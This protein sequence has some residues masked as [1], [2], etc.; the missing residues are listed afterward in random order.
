MLRALSLL[1]LI[2]FAAP[3]AAQSN[4]QNHQSQNLQS[5]NFR[6]QELAEAAQAYREDLL[7]AVPVAKRQPAL[8]P[9]LR[10]DADA[11]YRAKRY[12]QA[13]DDLTRAINFG[14]DDGL[15]WL[16]LAQAFAGAQDEK[17]MVSAYNAYTRSTDPVERG[18]ALFLIGREYDRHDKMK[19]A[20]AAFEAGLGFTQAAAIS[21][22]VEQLRR[23]V[24]FRVTKV[25]ITSDADSPRACLRFNEKISPR[26]DLSFGGFIRATPE[27]AGVVTA[28]GDTLCLDGL[29]HGETYQVEIM[30]GFPADTGDKT[31]AD[32]SAHMVVADRQPSM[33]FSGAG[34]V[35]PREGSAGLPLTTINLDKV[36]VRLVRINERNLVPTIDA[37]K[38]TMSFDPDNVDEIINQDG[39]LV[40][41]GEMAVSGERNRPVVTAIPLSQILHDKGP[42]VYLAVV[43][44][45]DV[46]AGDNPPLVTNWVLVS[47]LGLTTYTGTDGMAV[48]VRSLADAKPLSGVTLRLYARNNGELTNLIT[49]ADGLARIPPGL[50]HGTGGDEPFVIM[51]STQN[52]DF[53]FLEVSRGAFDLSDRGVSGRPQPGPVDAYLYTDRGIYRPGEPV[54]LMTLIRDDKADSLATLPITLRLVRPDG[55]EVDHRQVTGDKL[56]GHEETYQLARDASIGTWRI[57]ARADPKGPAIGSVDI[58]VEDFVPPQLKVEMSASDA[59]VRPGEDYP[60]N[61]AAR[62]YYGAP[63]AELAV[64]AHATVAIDDNPYPNE[65]GFSFGLADEEFS[66][67]RKDIDVSP[68]DAEGKANIALA[69]GDLPEHT[70]PLAATVDVS[71]FEPSGRAVSASLTRP[72]R[73]RPLAIGLHLPNGDD[74]NGVAD[75]QPAAL[76]AIALDNTGKRVPAKGLHWELLSETA[77]YTWYSVNGRWRHR[78]QVHDRSVETGTIDAGTVPATLSRN[79]PSGRYRWE[80]RDNASGAQSSLR[81]HVGWWTDAALPDVPDKLTTTLDKPGYQA[82]ET[83]KLFIKAPFAGE[84]EVAIASDRILVMRSITLPAEGATIELPVDAAWGTGVYAL[85]SAYRPLGTASP[86]GALPRGPGRAVGVAWLGIDA[87]PRKLTVALSAPQVARPRGP[88]DIPVKVTGAAAG[89]E[90]YVTLAAVDEAVL[91]LT[92]FE[93]PAPEKYYF[94]KRQLGVELRDLYGRLID[95]RANAIGVLRSGGDQF[96][97]RAVTGLPDRSSRVVALFSGIVKLDADGGAKI[98]LDVP[99]FQGQLR[100]MAVAFSAHKLGSATG[101]VTVRDPVVTMVS[102]PRFLAPGDTAQIGLV[103]N[104]LEGPAGDYH[105]KF[106]ADGAGAFTAPVNRTIPLTTGQNFNATFPVTAAT[107]GNIALHLDLTGPGDTHIAR[108]FTLG[109]RPGQPYQLRRF[110]AKLEPGQ[111]I[112]LDDGAADEFLPG[113]AEALLTVSP[114]PDWDVPGLLRSLHRYAYGCIEQTT[115]RALPLL[116]VDSVAGLWRTDP[117]FSPVAALDD[118]IGRIVGMQ[119][120]DGSFGVWNDTDDTVP[121]LDA[122]ATDFLLR[123]QEHG[124]TVPDY[125]LKAAIGWLHD[126]VRQ[127]HTDEKSLPAVAYAHYVLAHAKADDLPVLRYFSDTQLSNLPTQLARAQ[128]AGALAAYGDMPRATAAYQAAVAPPPKRP[129]NLRYVD[130]GS[131]LR[132]SAG[133]LA[134]AGGNPALQPQLTAVMD[135]IT[136]LF[137]RRTRTSTQEQAWL[138]MAAEAAV[139]ATGGDMTVAVGDA[140]AQK[141]TEPLYF[142]RLLGIGATPVSVANRGTGPAWRTVSITGVPKAD[143]PAEN[144]GYTVSRSIF[145]ADGSPADLTKAR[146]TDL[147]VVVLKAKR[148]D[149]SRAARALVVDLLPA[150]FEIQA[151]SAGGD[152]SGNYSWLKDLTNT[153]YTEARDDRYVAAIDMP[154]NT[155]DITLAYVV[156]AVTPGQFKYPALVVEDMYEPETTGRTAMGTLNVQRR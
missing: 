144:S 1:A 151:A 116:Y 13:I 57:E 113:T 15:V 18:T 42:G 142:R 134:F 99:D 50:V 82:G 55:V 8:I 30:A 80:V 43:D 53:N 6:S 22:R 124:K 127:S 66:S 138:L 48:A 112:T 94:D 88:V 129:P 117:G 84:A 40:W 85:V 31:I 34:Y 128:L 39:S 36:K 17:V 109:V 87:A 45:L 61:V 74:D 108:D 11:E 143:L 41:Q 86:I 19:E 122:Y 5:Q 77:E 7:G 126:Y 114:R 10:R 81:F 152:S 27:I 106:T 62:Y 105:V 14:A 103:I 29:K 49:G 140:A 21:E 92:D 23:L 72:V 102:L 97:K 147:F 67:D 136:E 52:G 93:S 133:V 28:R 56:G 76:E 130:Y 58:R 91:K 54:H 83:A 79:L 20:L 32:Y 63:G 132:D 47:N 95:P 25:D 139:R 155:A 115:S 73:E 123:A 59:P 137:A 107:S 118:A 125:A 100:L 44:R 90:A 3:A 24:A 69:L 60:V 71:V 16:R 96:A 89:E 131:D 26:A 64:E 46:K 145:R 98:R 33:S 110:V 70:K 68:T 156:R 75:G 104:N 9:R 148:T 2:L 146:Q 150:G 120:S 101:A 51:A 65:P 38:L 37:N 141:R 154:E 12:V 111:S 153:A 78:M 35:L 135:R 4:P 149:A 119:R 121:W